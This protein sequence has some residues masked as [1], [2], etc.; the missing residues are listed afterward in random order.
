[1]RLRIHDPA[2]GDSKPTFDFMHGGGW[3]LFSLDTH[4]RVMREFAHRGGMAVVGVDYALS[5]E[6][7]YPTALNQVVAVVHWLHEHG[8]A[9]GLD[10]ERI[11]IGG[12]SAGGN[13]SIGTVLRLRD[14][15]HGKPVKAVQNIDAGSTPDCSPASRQRYGTEQDMLTATE[16]DTFW[17][18]YIGH[19]A[20]RRDPYAAP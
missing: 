16:V 18:N 13:L 15:G 4:D 5:P 14:A 2:P 19:V 8:R 12:D 1:V 20:D 11:G 3:S 9:H 10:G 6:A 7:R 17:D